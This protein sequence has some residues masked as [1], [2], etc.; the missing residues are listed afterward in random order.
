MTPSLRT[1]ARLWEPPPPREPNSLKPA[2][3][4]IVL[5]GAGGSVERVLCEPAA[6]DVHVDLRRQAA[7]YR[8]HTIV[9]EW[10]GERGWCRWV[11]MVLG[12]NEP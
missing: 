4:R 12:G 7:E 6:K 11:S 8:G 3:R 10:L 2:R 9:A 5:L 1:R